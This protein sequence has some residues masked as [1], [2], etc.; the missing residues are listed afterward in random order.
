VKKIPLG[1]HESSTLEFKQK[2]SLSHPE[3]IGREIV[4]MLNSDGGEVWI[5]IKEQDGTSVSVDS[6]DDPDSAK[7]SLRDYLTDVLEPPPQ[8]DE[9][10]IGIEK[11]QGGRAVLWILI[12]PSENRKP[13]A[14]L[15][16]SGRYFYV[17][18]GDR[19]RPMSREEIFSSRAPS[20]D[21][22]DLSVAADELRKER[23][24]HQHKGESVY[25]IVLK[26][27]PAAKI[28]IQDPGIR[29]YLQDATQT[30]NRPHGW[31]FMSPYEEPEVRKGRLV[32]GTKVGRTIEVR[33]NG[34]L[35]LTIGS[36]GLVHG[37]GEREI[38][39]FALIEYPVALFRLASCLY[40]NLKV[41]NSGKVLADAALI[42]VQGWVLRPYSPRSI[43]F[44]HPLGAPNAWTEGR[45]LV[46]ER[47]LIFPGSEIVE[48][49]DWCGFRLVRRIYEAFGYL[50]DK[51]PLEFD[52]SKRRLIIAD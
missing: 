7:R 6:I 25:W 48:E 41:A 10:D 36:E 45:D 51:I 28:D 43:H 49:P 39:P 20:K 5:G 40:R 46:W 35:S 31:N 21:P 52:R 44:Q 11:D 17:R 13:Y 47:A 42:G 12:Q 23:E 2:D 30:G 38:Y 29:G 3:S 26:P 16:G 1:R 33:D 50:E 8:G 19:L 22:A 27:Q 14:L 37:R 32:Q 18:V 15:K 24:G 34:T 9:V 4:G